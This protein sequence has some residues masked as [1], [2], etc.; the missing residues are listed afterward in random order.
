LTLPS[1]DWLPLLQ[2]LTAVSDSWGVWK[3]ADRALT[4]RGDVDSTAPV[5]QHGLVRH[6][7]YDWATQAGLQWFIQCRHAGGVLILVAL[8]HDRWAQLDI[9]FAPTFRGARL[10]L[11]EDLVP[12]MV[13]DARGFRRLR[14][15]AEGLFLFLNKGCRWGGRPNWSNLTK[16]HVLD[17]IA[18]DWPGAEA[19]SALLGSARSL[20][21]SGAHAAMTGDWNGSALLEAEALIAMRALA[22]PS[23]LASRA[24]ARGWSLPRCWVVKAID[25][26]RRPQRL[27]EWLQRVR[28]RHTVQAIPRS[29]I[30][31]IVP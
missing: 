19:V 15:G 26:G 20:V 31:P 8:D 22:H 2:R 5:T 25:A 23:V 30:H 3:N 29:R 16:Y 28:E 4:G 10:F 12:L 17:K 7:F 24:I 18:R 14:D 6:E 21:L 9:V 27:E 1:S 11:A 13:M